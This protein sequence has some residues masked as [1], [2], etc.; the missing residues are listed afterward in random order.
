MANLKKSKTVVNIG[1]DVGKQFLDI[2]IHWDMG[3]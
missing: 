3:T 1:V 2:C